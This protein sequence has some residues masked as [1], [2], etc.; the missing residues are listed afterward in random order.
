MIAFLCGELSNSAKYFSSFANVSTDDATVIDGTL[1]DGNSS[2]LTAAKKVD[3]L[4][5]KISKQQLTNNTKRSKITILIAST[6]SRQEFLPH[7]GKLID[8]IHIAIE[9]L[10]LTNNACALAH[11]YL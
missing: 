2:R 9:P 3:E 7:L 5:K 10:H 11:K 8:R 6:K 4:T 1:I